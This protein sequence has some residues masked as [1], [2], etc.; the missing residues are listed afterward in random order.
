MG[1]GI[2]QSCDRNLTEWF[3]ILAEILRNDTGPGK[4]G[5]ELVHLG[6]GIGPPCLA[7]KK[8]GIVGFNVKRRLRN[9]SRGSTELATPLRNWATPLRNWTTPPR[10]W[11]APLRNWAT[12]LRN[13]PMSTEWRR[14]GN[15]EIQRPSFSG[16][17]RMCLEVPERGIHRFPETG[18][19][20]ETYALSLFSR[21]PPLIP[22]PQTRTA[23][24]RECPH[25]GFSDTAFC[26]LVVVAL[27]ALAL[28]KSLILET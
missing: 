20:C 3:W 5:T 11:A 8:E 27:L 21:C 15:P 19:L 28:G 16:L 6:H 24:L 23:I 22:V 13:S 2:G 14:S 12:P 4:F 18:A 9:V 7:D 26:S 17:S 1:Y 10:N 25:L